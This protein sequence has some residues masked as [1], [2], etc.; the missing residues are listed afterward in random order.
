AAVM[1]L[2]IRKHCTPPHPRDLRLLLP[3]PACLECIA[4]HLVILSTIF[5][6]AT[7]CQM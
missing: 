2:G 5:S 1:V 4:F 6:T 3:I 7:F